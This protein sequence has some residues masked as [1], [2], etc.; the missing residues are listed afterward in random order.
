VFLGLFALGCSG[1][2]SL[3]GKRMDNGESADQ[4]GEDGSAGPCGCPDAG[5]DAV[6]L[7]ANFGVTFDGMMKKFRGPLQPRSTMEFTN[8]EV[9]CNQYQGEPHSAYLRFDGKDAENPGETA[10]AAM[11]LFCVSDVGTDHA[12]IVAE[13]KAEYLPDADSAASYRHIRTTTYNA[14]QPLI[15][16]WFNYTW[17][18]IWVEKD[19]FGSA[20]DSGD[21]KEFHANGIL[22]RGEYEYLSGDTHEDSFSHRVVRS[23]SNG[24]EWIEN[25]Q[26]KAEWSSWN[27]GVDEDLTIGDKTESWACN[28]MDHVRN[29][30]FSRYSGNGDTMVWG[31]GSGANTFSCPYFYTTETDAPACATTV[32]Q[33][34]QGGCVDGAL[35]PPVN[36]PPVNN[37]VANDPVV[38]EPPDR[39]APPT[40][41][42]FI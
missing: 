34:A 7:A 9:F 17:G 27:R 4:Y 13:E 20:D 22:Q 5:D 8:H 38:I 41:P 12:W 31:Q 16:D 19:E 42:G 10:T 6:A 21:E 25:G 24:K 26:R 33:W 14:H 1:G 39:I 29:A 28:F 30:G 36:N 3:L 18:W 37:P 11:R 40:R 23:G 2:E 32:E 35:N 15:P